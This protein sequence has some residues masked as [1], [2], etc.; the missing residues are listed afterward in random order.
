MDV[1]KIGL[2]GCGKQ[3]P[4]HISGLRKIPGVEIVLADIKKEIA[5]NLAQKEG[6][7][8]KNHPDEIFNDR[9]I[10]AVDICTP[11]ST[12]E[13]LIN[14]AIE[15]GKD[16]FCEK[17]LCDNGK[18]ANEILLAAEKHRRIGMVG[19]IYRFAPVFEKA[20]E[21]LRQVDKFGSCQQLGEIVTANLRIG[22]RGSHQLWKH[23]KDSAGGAI[24]EMLV[25]ML[26]LAIWFFG[27]V[28]DLEVLS[29]ELLRPKR[30]I[31]GREENVDAEDFVLLKMVMKSG[32]MVVC[33]ADLLT[34][35]FTQFVEIQG[36]SGSFMGSIQPDMPSFI[37][38][39]D[40]G[41]GL[42]K[43]KTNFEFGPKNLFDA[44]MADF[45][46]AVRS[47]KQP[48]RCTIND[49]VLLL[50]TLDLIKERIYKR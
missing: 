19:Y 20:V 33:Q 28:D 17:P 18:A 39:E 32:V 42:S 16:F 37:F 41:N 9:T 35:A 11:T 8:I 29:S 50:E 2:V 13:T 44:Q 31:Q 7:E 15:S 25:H 10:N 26:D 36:A 30:S 46:T 49:S 12:H 43:G 24:N 48:T 38:S 21:I 5:L 23:R 1:I 22:G 6:L 14:S 4:K 27:P 45:V 40:G 47:Q 34:P 3:A